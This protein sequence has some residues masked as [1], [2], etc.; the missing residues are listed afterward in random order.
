MERE[1]GFA[2]ALAQYRATCGELFNLIKDEEKAKIRRWEDERPTLELLIGSLNQT[3]DILKKDKKRLAAELSA[4]QAASVS[5][6]GPQGA[7]QGQKLPQPDHSSHHGS[8]DTAALQREVDE[9]NSRMLAIDVEIKIANQELAVCERADER[10]YLSTKCVVLQ[11]TRRILADE[12]QALR[13]DLARLDAS[14]RVEAERRRAEES[15][16]AEVAR[17]EEALERTTA[18]LDRVKQ[19]LYFPEAKGYRF[20]SGSGGIYVAARDLHVSEVSGRFEFICEPIRRRAAVAAATS[21]GGAAAAAAAAAHGNRVA[22]LTVALG[23]VSAS[24][25]QADWSESRRGGSAAA[26]DSFRSGGGGGGGRHSHSN[27]NLS[28]QSSLTGAGATA[29]AEGDTSGGGGLDPTALAPPPGGRAPP[30]P[31]PPPPPQPQPH[32]AA[33]ASARSTASSSPSPSA[34]PSPGTPTAAGS[35]GSSPQTQPP[36][37]TPSA[38]PPQPLLSPQPPHPLHPLQQQQHPL[39]HHPQQQQQQPQQPHPQQA[40]GLNQHHQQQQQQRQAGRP[41]PGL[42]P[43]LP[44][45]LQQ[46]YLRQQQ[47]FQQQQQQQHQQHQQQQPQQQPPGLAAA[48]AQHRRAPSHDAAALGRGGG[49]AAAGL[50]APPPPPPRSKGEA[51]ANFL[52]SLKN[53]KEKLKSVVGGLVG[54]REEDG[55]DGPL[56]GGGGDGGGGGGGGG[57]RLRTQMMEKLQDGL[58]EG[59]GKLSRI[60]KAIATKA[61]EALRDIKTK[62]HR[63]AGR[64]GSAGGAGEA[65]EWEAGVASFAAAAAS[66]QQQQLDGAAL[67][68]AALLAAATADAYYFTAAGAAAATGPTAPPPLTATR[69]FGGGGGGAG[70]RAAAGRDSDLVDWDGAGTAGSVASAPAATARAVEAPAALGGGDGVSV[71]GGGGSDAYDADQLGGFVEDFECRPSRKGVYVQ[72]LGERVELLGERGTKVPD[73][74]IRELMLEVEVAVTAVFEYHAAGRGGG[75]GGAR[76]AGA[77]GGGGGGGGAWLAPEPVS[78]NILQLEH[79]MRGN[80]LP[81]PKTLLKGLLNAYM[82]GLLTGLLSGLLPA[83]LGAYTAASGETQALSGEFKVAGPS[84][85]T[86]VTSIAPPPKPPSDPARRAQWAAVQAAAGRA[87][88]MLGL[89]EGQAA[90][91]SELFGGCGRPSLMPE[92]AAY[93]PSISGLCRFYVSYSASGLWTP[94]MG[95]LNRALQSAFEYHCVPPP[96]RFP[97]SSFLEGSVARLVRK[98]LRIAFTIE[99]LSLALECDAA[100][101]TVRDFFERLAREFEAKGAHRAGGGGGGAGGGSG[102]GGDSSGPP[103]EPLEVQL[104]LLD[105]W[106]AS[107]AKLLRTFKQRFRCGGATLLASAD[108]RVFQFGA[109]SVSYDGPLKLKL[110]LDLAMDPDGSFLLD[111]KLPDREEATKSITSLLTEVMYSLSTTHNNNTPTKDGAGGANGGGGNGS[112]AAAG[113]GGGAA[114]AAGNAATPTRVA[115][116]AG[117]S[118]NHNGGVPAAASGGGGSSSDLSSAFAT[119]QQQQQQQAAQQQQVRQQASGALV[120]PPSQASTA[121]AVRARAAAVQGMLGAGRGGSGGGAAAAAGGAGSSGGGGQPQPQPQPQQQRASS[122]VA[123]VPS[124]SALFDI[125]HEWAAALAEGMPEGSAVAAGTAPLLSNPVVGQL[126]VKKLALNLRLDEERV[127]QLLSAQ[128]AGVGAAALAA[129]AAV[130][131]GGGG[132]AAAAATGPGAAGDIAGRLLGCYGDLFT[133]SLDLG[134]RPNSDSDG[135]AAQRPCCMLTVASNDITRLR[136]EVEGLWFQSTVSPRLAVRV[137][138]AVVIAL[139][140]KF[141]SADS[142]SIRFWNRAFNQLHEYLSR[143]SLDLAV[144]LSLRATMDRPTDRLRLELS[145]QDLNAPPQQTAAGGGGGGGGGGGQGLL[146]RVCPVYLLNDVNLMTVFDSVKLLMEAAPPA[147]GQQGQGQQGQGQQEE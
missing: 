105:L 82:P 110:P 79:R 67:D 146:G 117:A 107:L 52:S 20:S 48:A 13:S 84:L 113:G 96:E 127:A 116:A 63:P 144:C 142:Y 40:A 51:V 35:G 69:S 94:L 86:T 88:A 83:E 47:Q 57:G 98:P 141:H 72:L 27:S 5:S 2:K 14:S 119:V 76:P 100:L 49:A 130:A 45:H 115:N 78:F 3:C 41:P 19:Q 38:Q 18:R 28:T 64:S 65:G 55:P 32:P 68:P 56:G 120:E 128:P 112:A 104:D 61:P 33:P 62:I 126:C 60:S 102:S 91:V 90:A 143:G 118:S 133:A 11:D 10:E 132:G 114:A 25:A 12:V 43:G 42:P 37:P 123:T 23:G 1:R 17:L 93:T 4:K 122:P 140:L 15:G 8:K 24:T 77:I 26:G 125:G 109:E 135:S 121:Q 103:R 36:A 75:G 59:K 16:W 137:L 34:S 46:Q 66:Q 97:L 136:A 9:L 21:S 39:Q 70:Q 99:R 81:L 124:G 85:S 111:V 54:E 73:T 30:Q 95:V 80:T 31:P 89:S 129:A 53:K 29:V 147:G 87:R 139:V 58:S 145:G 44:P 92:S 50:T 134:W 106:H 22:R 101:A 131:A 71:G 138:Q 7:R 108:R 74:S 6:S